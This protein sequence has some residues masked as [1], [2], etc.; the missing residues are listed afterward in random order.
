MFLQLHDGPEM[1]YGLKKYPFPKY[2]GK[3]MPVST[4]ENPY[5]A[6]APVMKLSPYAVL[7]GCDPAQVYA[8]FV[9][10]SKDGWKVTVNQIEQG[11]KLWRDFQSVRAAAGTGSAPVFDS[12]GNITGYKQATKLEEALV[13]YEMGRRAAQ[14]IKQGISNAEARRLTDDAQELW[15]QNK[16]GLQNLCNQSLSQ[17]KISAE[18]CYNS[19]QWWLL[20][21]GKPGRSAGQKRVA[22]RA[23]LLRQNA[24]LLIVKQIEEKGGKFTPGGPGGPGAEI[25]S[26]AILA[27]LAA[28]AFLRF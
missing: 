10:Q 15:D 19:L 4:A 17:L 13:Y 25:N 22:N 1:P 23:V 27:A 12:N 28:L 16:W 26:G 9:P 14:I 21:Q 2:T 24:L 3:L 6:G 7:N 11:A 18:N 5:A 20:D 8:Q